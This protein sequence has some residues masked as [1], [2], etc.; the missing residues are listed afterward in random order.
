M[1]Y[2]IIGVLLVADELR[3]PVGP[4]V[5][6]AAHPLGTGRGRAGPFAGRLCRWFL[7]ERPFGTTVLELQ[8]CN[9]HTPSVG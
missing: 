3:P 1:M 6:G 8:H 7:I 5:R 4:G 2:W 9:C